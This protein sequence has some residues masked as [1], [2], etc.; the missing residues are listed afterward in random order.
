MANVCFH[1]NFIHELT[2]KCLSRKVPVACAAKIIYVSPPAD[3]IRTSSHDVGWNNKLLKSWRLVEELLNLQS[4]REKMSFG[5]T[6]R[7]EEYQKR[8]GNVN[9]KLLEI[10]SARLCCAN[11]SAA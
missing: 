9:S 11:R 1:V 8:S 3:S 5:S 10:T 7:A 4:D 2:A 6:L